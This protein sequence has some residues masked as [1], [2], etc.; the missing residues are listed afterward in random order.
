M[1]G[2][3]RRVEKKPSVQAG[4]NLAQNWRGI[5]DRQTIARYIGCH[6]G[7]YSHHYFIAIVTSGV[8]MVEEVLVTLQVQCFFKG[9]C[10]P[11]LQILHD[12]SKCALRLPDH[13]RCT[14][15]PH[16]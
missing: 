14:E 16:D 2:A 11:F 10:L 1:D 3:L 5:S 7:P 12:I 6:H 8:M 13:V 4:L 15:V 9:A